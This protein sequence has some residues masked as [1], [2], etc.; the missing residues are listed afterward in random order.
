MDARVQR[1]AQFA[2]GNFDD[3]CQAS[4]RGGDIVSHLFLSLPLS[5]Q[6]VSYL[7]PA[8]D[9]VEAEARQSQYSRV[10]SP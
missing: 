6:K 9:F 2:G 3:W 10:R 8:C 4:A 7:F 5:Q 1:P